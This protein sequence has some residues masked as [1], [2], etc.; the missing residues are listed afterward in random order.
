[1][2]YSSTRQVVI[3]ALEGA[4]PDSVKAYEDDPVVI[5][6]HIVRDALAL[7]RESV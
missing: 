1:M 5:P 6:T 4:M 2:Q 3:R 7:L